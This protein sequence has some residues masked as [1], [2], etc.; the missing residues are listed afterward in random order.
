M[1]PAKQ[2][3]ALTR[4]AETNPQLTLEEIS[5]TSGRPTPDLQDEKEEAA[6]KLTLR[7][8]ND[9]NE[10]TDVEDIDL[11]ENITTM[12]YARNTKKDVPVPDSL[13]ILP[14]HD[15]HLT[16][17]NAVQ[18]LKQGRFHSWDRYF[19]EGQALVE[20]HPRRL[21]FAIVTS[22][23]QGLYAAKQHEQC[24]QWLD[25]NGWTWESVAHFGLSNTPSIPV[26][27][28]STD[29]RNTR[30]SS[31]T[32]EKK[33]KGRQDQGAVSKVP[34]Q[35]MKRPE[36]EIQKPSTFMPQASS[37]LRQQSQ[38]ANGAYPPKEAGKVRKLRKTKTRS[39][40]RPTKWVRARRDANGRL[41]SQRQSSP[42]VSESP[43]QANDHIRITGRTKVAPRRNCK[44]AEHHSSMK[45]TNARPSK[46]QAN[47]AIGD[48]EANTRLETSQEFP[49][50]PGTPPCQ[51]TPAQDPEQ[52]IPRL[53][54]RRR[55]IDR[56]FEKQGRKRR[57]LMDEEGLSPLPPQPFPRLGNN[58]SR[59]RKRRRL[60][61]PPPPEIPIMPTSDE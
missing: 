18:S 36:E 42:L 29:P 10:S 56:I 59:R 52:T 9:R 49:E 15:S 43:S 4:T 40:R 58:E 51:Q 2:G 57:R 33:A 37:P 50:C 1:K 44:P 47:G 12:S 14:Q 45:H 34:D 5:R 27:L 39:Q 48:P 8:A 46:Q 35:S 28:E 31:E 23:V 55:S 19:T 41:Q 16:Q 61:L 3:C 21:E 32:A 60:P 38:L 30:Q 13:V 54:K 20:K 11:D 53:V 22:F 25:V 26:H 6:L 17:A 24:E 7:D